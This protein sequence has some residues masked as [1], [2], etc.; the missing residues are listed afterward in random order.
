[1]QASVVRAMPDVN[2]CLENVREHLTRHNL[3]MNEPEPVIICR[4]CKFSLGDSPNAVANHLAE[5]H[6]VPKSTTKELRRLLGPYTFLGPEALRLRPDESTPHPH[7]Q[8]QRGIACRHCSLKTTSHEVLSRDLS[9]NHGVKRK[10]PTWLHDHVVS[11]LSLQSWGWHT[12][13]GY[14]IVKPESSIALALDD[15]LLQDSVPRL[16]RLEALHRKERDR[17]LVRHKASATDSGNTDMALNTNW[18]RRTGWAETFADA[19]R[20]FLVKLAHMPQVAEHGLLLGT[21]NG[22]DLYSCKADEQ[23]L[24]LMVAALGRVFDQCAD[25]VRHTDVSMRCWLRSQFVDRPYKAPFELVGRESTSHGYQRLMKRCV[26]F[27][28]RLWRMSEEARQQLA[29]RT[30]TESECQALAQ[31]WDDDVWS[32]H[33]A[34]EAHKIDNQRTTAR[35]P[36]T[37]Q[38]VVEA[39]DEDEADSDD[40]S[41]I[42]D[43]S[44][45]SLESQLEQDLSESEANTSDC[46][47]EQASGD[48]RPMA[49][50][51][52]S[53]LGLISSP[54]EDEVVTTTGGEKGLGLE[55]ALEDLMLRFG[56]F[57]VTE[58]YEDGISSSTLLVYFSGILGISIDG[59]TFERPS[60]YTSKLSALIYCSRLLIIEST[61]S[62]FAHQ[63]IEWPAR[64][65]HNQ[66]EQLNR[67]RRA[68]MCLGSQAPMDEFLSLRNY[69]RAISRSDGPA[70][71]VTWSQDADIV[72]W[73]GVYLSMDQFRKI[74]HDTID[75]A[76]AVCRQMMYEW[77]PESDL[78]R[79]RDRLS[80]TAL[81]YSFVTDPANGLGEAYLELSR[82]ACLATVNGLMTDDDWDSVAV[83]HYLD[84]YDH[85]T[86]LLVLLVYFVGGQ[87]PRGT[88]LFALEHCNGASTSRGVCVHAGKMAL[89]SR[90]HKAR[91]TTNSEFHVVRFL[92]KEPSKILY[93]YLVF[94]RPFACMLFRICYNMDAES[95]LLFSSP[96]RPTEPIKTSILS[97][98]LREQTISTLGFPVGVQVY[99]QLSIAI[100]EKH[101]KQVANP[102]NQH[103]DKSKEADVNVSFA[104]QSGHRPLQRGTTYG[105]DG[106]FPDSLQPALL[107]VYEWASNEWHEFLQLQPPDISAFSN[108]RERQKRGVQSSV[109]FEPSKRRRTASPPKHV[110]HPP[111]QYHHTLPQ[112]SKHKT[113]TGPWATAIEAAFYRTAPKIFWSGSVPIFG[114]PS[115]LERDSVLEERKLISAH[116]KSQEAEVNKD[117]D[118][119]H[120]LHGIEEAIVRWRNVGCQLCYASTGEPEPDH[121]LEHC[122]RRDV[123]D[124]ARKM[125]N[126]LQDLKLPRLVPG[127]GA[128]SLCSMTDFPCGDIVAGI[129]SDEADCD[130]VKQ[131]WAN[132]LKGSPFG[133]GECQNK[134]VVKRTI[135][136]LCAYDDQILGKYLS[137]RLRD[138][139]D[140]DF[141]AQNLVAL[142]FEKRISFRNNSVLRLLFV[143]ELLTSAFDFRR[144]VS[145]AAKEPRKI[146][147]L[148]CLYEQ[149]WDDDDELQGWQN[150][151]KWWV[152]KCGFCA[153]RGLS[154]LKINHTLGECSRGGA[155]Q[156]SLRIG[157]AIFG[158]G[159]EAQGGCKRC[160]IPRE[161]CDKWDKSIDGHWQLQPLM[162]CQYGRLAYETVVGL[163]QCSDTRYALDLLTTIEEEGEEEYSLLGDEEV[164]RWLCKKLVVSGVEG[165]ELM[166]QLWVW[167]RMVH[168]AY[169]TNS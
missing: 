23:R 45:F 158:E 111:L 121:D 137:E 150:T 139:N 106:A 69:G 52:D 102:F 155:K 132:L 51:L 33:P 105:L 6:N 94:I 13:A 101:V 64:P 72:S 147:D 127:I 98:I 134:P 88:E 135:A 117:L 148:P 48:L 18:M 54:R 118:T 149:G 113:R 108:T 17:L 133:D 43:G 103:D 120:R 166:R 76:T 122:R 40:A 75:C 68:K 151:M 154:G 146:E 25:T 30:L 5:K 123:S 160:G 156:R 136:A 144:S 59:S 53:S 130:E 10:S 92:S 128:C 140:L 63:Y 96:V 145:A 141:M 57:L 66:S 15:S 46:E 50:R 167:T 100:T 26:C 36:S 61:L 47:L 81:G 28:F 58:E 44:E 87:A 32:L 60:N 11:G 22:T 115:P 16:S 7:L 114:R 67:V 8:V 35:C 12:A 99:R 112:H 34:E 169:V 29:K 4:S 165:A 62:H 37:M 86:R 163:F 89:I 80:N 21:S 79:I 116:I 82:R 19:D 1:M 20:S 110:E 138:E 125:F 124:K 162:Q 2:H 73:A 31:V 152:G 83:R 14:W 143:F 129:R 65:R 49:K 74:S 93:H 90:H 3:F 107:R 161:L 157:E 164:S 119:P 126:W 85:L 55:A 153:G 24:V 84:R 142:W 27:C 104:W 131:H 42:S 9:K 39:L 70:F 77:C 168:K 56:Y 109:D 71:R 159:I 38:E 91:R 95:T 97:K 78:T 41:T